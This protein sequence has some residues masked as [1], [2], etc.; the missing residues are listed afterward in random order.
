MLDI[1]IFAPYGTDH[2]RNLAF[3]QD[4]GVH[5]IAM[6]AAAVAGKGTDG[7]PAPDTLKNLVQTYARGGVTLAALTPPRISLQA[8]SDAGVREQEMGVIRRTLTAMGEAGVPFLHL[9]LSNEPAPSDPAEKARLWEGLADIYREL[10]AVSEQAGV[11]ISTHHYHLPDRLLWNCHTMSRMMDEVGSPANGVIFCQ[12]KSQMAGDDLAEAIRTFG[13]KIFMVHLRDVV[14]RVSGPVSEEVQKRLMSY[15]YLEVALGTGEVD[16]VGTVRALKQI[17]YSG[18]VYP[19]HFPAIAGDR[20]AGLA[21]TIG[22]IRALD[23]L[24]EV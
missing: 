16:M 9:Y 12:G 8:L 18:Q 22:Y 5:H 7:V 3:C 21:W 4:T 6:G 11:L 17:G 23:Q 24:V 19:E 13:D 1:G 10:S 20:A 2:D 14:T 15:G